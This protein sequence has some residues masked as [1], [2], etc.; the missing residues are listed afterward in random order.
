MEGTSNGKY[1]AYKF[2]IDMHEQKNSL[3]RLKRN[4]VFC[5]NIQQ[6]FNT[7]SVI[8]SDIYTNYYRTV[9]TRSGM[10]TVSEYNLILK[11]VAHFFLK[12]R[13]KSEA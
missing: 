13:V 8:G 4:L 12:K 1:L 10:Y 3:T 6:S 11:C 9:R 5:N 7:I 2:K